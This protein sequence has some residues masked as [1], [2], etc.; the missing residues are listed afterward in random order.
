MNKLLFSSKLQSYKI[1]VAKFYKEYNVMTFYNKDNWN[2]T[3]LFML[4]YIVTWHIYLALIHIF[5]LFH[6]S[7]NLLYEEHFQLSVVCWYSVGVE[8]WKLPVSKVMGR[9]REINLGE[10]SSL[11][12]W[13]RACWTGCRF[14]RFLSLQFSP[15]PWA[16]KSQTLIYWKKI[17]E[18]N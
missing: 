15:S 7:C 2:S 14:A 1:F 9:C 13:G 5:W 18:T 3:S 8:G 11:C 12:Y 10:L 4:W 17:E 6:F 16:C